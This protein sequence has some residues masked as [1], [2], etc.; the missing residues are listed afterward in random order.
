MT[1]RAN[2]QRSST[3]INNH[4]TIINNH[5]T[6]INN[7]TTINKQKPS[8]TS[9]TSFYILSCVE[10]HVKSSTITRIV[11]HVGSRVRG[12]HPRGA[13]ARHA[14]CVCVCVSVC[15]CVYTIL[16]HTNTHKHSQTLTNTHRQSTLTTFNM[17]LA[18]LSSPIKH[19]QTLT[20]RFPPVLSSSQRG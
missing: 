7:H 10:S 11:W 12:H 3:I 1:C 20:H 19:L 5:T 8:T 16:Y 14:G 13:T 15:V 17:S 4:T 9:T 18:S 6:I 2:H